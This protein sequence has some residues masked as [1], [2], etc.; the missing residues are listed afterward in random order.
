MLVCRLTATKCSKLEYISPGVFFVKDLSIDSCMFTGS[1]SSE[2]ES[3]EEESEEEEEEDKEEEEEVQE[4]EEQD[5][6]EHLSTSLL[7][8]LS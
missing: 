7:C 3:A 5:S 6:K 4:E 8:C 2:S 1:G